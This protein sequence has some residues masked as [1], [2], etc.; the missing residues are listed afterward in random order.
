MC[1]QKPHLLTS[2]VNNLDTETRI[3]YASSTEFYLAD[4]AAGTPWV[5][6]LPF[7]VHVVKRVETYG[8]VSRNR[9]VTRYTYHHGFYDGVE[10]EFRGFWRVD[11]LDTE[12][13][14]SLNESGQFLVGTNIDASSPA[15]WMPWATPC[16]PK[17]NIAYS[18]PG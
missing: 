15:P 18:R 9:F 12:E 5:T 17:A 6:N 11:L 16:M 14:A 3:E 8:Y 10:R 1:G 7:S 2:A 4:K 13:Y